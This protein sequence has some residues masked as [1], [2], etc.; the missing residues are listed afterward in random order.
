MIQIDCF[1]IED[2]DLFSFKSDVI[3]RA[4]EIIHIKEKWCMVEE[5]QHS[6]EYS[7]NG[8]PNHRVYLMVEYVD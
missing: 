8:I 4:G 6:F 5:V 7:K 3:P 2:G 1:H